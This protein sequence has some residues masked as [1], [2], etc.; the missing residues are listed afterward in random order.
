MLVEPQVHPALSL[1][2]T[3][4]VAVHGRPV[5]LEALSGT[6]RV[7]DSPRACH[8]LFLRLLII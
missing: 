1:G 4:A 6:V 5:L 7:R 2:V 3:G 8:C